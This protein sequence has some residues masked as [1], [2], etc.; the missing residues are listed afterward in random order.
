MAGTV[1]EI[2]ITSEGSATMRRVE[3]VRALEG[4]GLEGDRYCKG[5]G[6]WTRFGDVCEVTL[7]EVEDLEEIRA[8]GLGIENGEHRRNIITRGVRLA[9]L[10]G[11][12]FRVGEVI[13]KYDRPR[14]PCRHVQNLTEPGMTRALKRRGGI[15]ARVVE[16]G[17]IRAR[18]EIEPLEAPKRLP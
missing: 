9:D 4:C 11:T 14:P 18:D 5:T 3:E 17:H 12:R 15:C 7:I 16:G 8:E 6:Y 2:Y 13:L 10:R 1:E